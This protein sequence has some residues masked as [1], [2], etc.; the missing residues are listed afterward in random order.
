M[1][2]K[3]S[4]LR[5][6]LDVTARQSDTYILGRGTAE[7]E[8]NA[9]TVVHEISAGVQNPAAISIIP[10]GQIT[11]DVHKFQPV[12]IINNGLLSTLLVVLKRTIKDFKAAYV[13]HA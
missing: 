13:L 3:P 9:V 4:Q 2:N 8:E 10:T 12:G 5:K 6:G 7:N 11:K 1:K